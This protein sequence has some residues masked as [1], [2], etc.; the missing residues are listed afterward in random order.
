MGLIRW[1]SAVR[2]A[3]AWPSPLAAPVR[4][5]RGGGGGFGPSPRSAFRRCVSAVPARLFCCFFLLP[6]LHWSRVLV[7]SRGVCHGR[8]WFRLCPWC[9]PWRG[10]GGSSGRGRFVGVGAAGVAGRSGL[11]SGAGL[12][13]RAVRFAGRRV[14]VRPPGRFARLVCVGSP[15]CFRFSGLVRVWVAGARFRGQGAPAFRSVLP[16]G[17]CPLVGFAV[18]G[19]GVVALAG[20]RALPA[21]GAALVA[22][23]S[24]A[25]VRSGRSLVVG[26]AVGADAAVLASGLPVGSVRV[27][28]AFGP[29]GRGAVPAVSAV[30]PVLA[31]AQAGGAVSWWVGGPVAVPFASRLRSR[32]C[33]VALAG[34]AGLVVFFSS[35][36]SRGSLLAASL[37]ASRSLPVL[38]FP[39][40]FPGSSLPLLGAGSW[41]PC[42]RS[43]VWSSAWCWVPSQAG[44][45][46]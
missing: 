43:G 26:C 32:T 18:V 29:G 24:G 34:S 11:V 4:P 40:G 30:G 20:S 28:S 46:S 45:F 38:A 10:R 31:H 23:V 7:L 8:F 42:S 44:L 21:S 1:A 13:V 25:L 17:G 33:A 22:R 16:R 5:S 9:P 39:L 35:P 6:M 15:R 3:F 27:L 19:A 14:R 12:P 41:V 36:A 37:A 2:L